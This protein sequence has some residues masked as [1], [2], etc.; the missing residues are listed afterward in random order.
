MSPMPSPSVSANERTYAWY[1]S[2]MPATLP[3][4]DRDAEQLRSGCDRARDRVR[5]TPV[6]LRL[7]DREDRPPDDGGAER[8]QRLRRQ[9]HRLARDER[10]R[11]RLA[12]REL[13]EQP[14]AEPA[15]SDAVAGVA[16]A[17]VDAR[18]G[19]R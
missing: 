7:V 3:G 8:A 11:R 9:V 6:R 1:T 12:G 16:G 4:S 10:R 15:R 2:V 13:R 19:D 17:E 14:P 5:R 18:V